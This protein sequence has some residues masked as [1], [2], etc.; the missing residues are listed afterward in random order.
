MA[1][2][3]L[4][5]VDKYYKNKSSNSVAIWVKSIPYSSPDNV[6]L[7]VRW[8]DII[9]DTISWDPE[10]SMQNLLVPLDHQTDWIQ[11]NPVHGPDGA[12]YAV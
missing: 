9:N 4:F 7:I 12:Q 8:V 1:Q 2:K 5:E 11:V 6:C 10:D 3:I